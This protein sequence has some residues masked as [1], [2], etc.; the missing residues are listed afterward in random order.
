MSAKPANTKPDNRVDFGHS[1]IGPR[2]VPVALTRFGPEYETCPACGSTSDGYGPIVHYH[3]CPVASGAP[4]RTDP[5]REAISHL[6]FKEKKHMA[7]RAKMTLEGV[8]AQNWGGAKA[9][10]RCIYDPAKEEDKS[11]QK[12][13][14]SGMA[15]FQIDNPA[16]AAQL[17]IGKSYYFDITEA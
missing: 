7:I 16:A 12:A 13:T 3:E 4:T 9:I 6:L 1:A 2:E 15:E 5:L 11:F 17:V 8:Y 10:F 14:P